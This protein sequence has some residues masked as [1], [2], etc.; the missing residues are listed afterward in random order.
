MEWKTIESAPR[1]GTPILCFNRMV[2]VYS[3][4]FTTRWAGEPNET[5]YEG[6][7]CGF[8]SGTLG[9]Y[10]FGQWDCQP[11]HWMPLPTPPSTPE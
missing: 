6:F 3:T 5:G 11:S 9:G 1:D 8:W 2:G 7:P 10:P 4:A